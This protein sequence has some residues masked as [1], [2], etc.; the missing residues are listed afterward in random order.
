MA[1]FKPLVLN[2]GQVQQLQPGD[3]LDIPLDQQVAFLRA[4]LNLLIEWM[5][6]EGFEL[7]PELVAFT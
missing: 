3:A 4:R 1:D 5:V 2:A 7:P 6:A